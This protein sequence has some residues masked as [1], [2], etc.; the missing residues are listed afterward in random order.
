ME[1]KHLRK[2]EQFIKYLLE[3]H[4]HFK[5]IMKDDKEEGDCSLFYDLREFMEIIYEY[6]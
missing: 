3:N 4:Y 1:K 2:K 5:F 6:N